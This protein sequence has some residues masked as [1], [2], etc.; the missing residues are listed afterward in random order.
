MKLF[1]FAAGILA[2]LL[3]SI[4]AVLPLLPTVPFYLLSAWC[5]A[6]SFPRMDRWLRSRPLYQKAMEP[7]LNG[8]GLTM[9]QKISMMT[10][11]TVVMVF[12]FAAMREV[13]I[14]QI[15][16]CCVWLFH[17]LYFVFRI[18]TKLPLK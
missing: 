11:T 4:G 17:V 18:K 14:G 5:F 1:Y 16:L 10:G 3:G 12:A 8:D 15:A 6:R 13:L 7:F 2:F 9:R